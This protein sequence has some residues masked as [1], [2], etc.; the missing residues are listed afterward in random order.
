VA[1]SP[2]KLFQAYRLGRY[3]YIFSTQQY[4][5]SKAS[6]FCYARGYSPVP[7]DKKEH[8]GTHAGTHLAFEL[9]RYSARSSRPGYIRVWGRA[10]AV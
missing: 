5:Y 3:M 4:S 8:A 7:Y 10:G 9:T 1:R 6:D 2:A